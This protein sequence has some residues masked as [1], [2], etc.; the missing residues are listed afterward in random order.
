MRT[1]VCVFGT[2][3]EA[4]KL[5]PLVLQLQAR[6]GFEVLTVST[7]QHREMVEQ[8]TDWFG[9]ELDHD[10]EIMAPRQSLTDIVSRTSERLPPVLGEISPDL[11]VVQGDTSTAFLG[12]L[13]AFYGGIPV[14][15]VEAGLRTGTI[16]N[17]FP[18][19]LNRV[20]ISKIAD[21]HF[22]PSALARSNLIADGIDRKTIWMTG[23]TGVDAFRI[24]AGAI[25]PR[26]P[27]DGHGQ[28]LLVTLH[29]RE[30]WG[31][32]LQEACQ[33]LRML[34]DDLPELEIVFPMHA[35][36]VVRETVEGVL[37]GLRRVKLVEHMSYPEFCA[38]I[39]RSTLVL[40][41]SGGIQEEAPA[42]GVPVLVYRQTT[43]RQ[44]AIDAGTARLVPLDGE[45]VRSVARDLLTDPVRW[46][47][48][49]EA[50]NPYG[51][52]FA[53]GRIVDVLEKWFTA[54]VS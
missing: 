16:R 30:N 28:R 23:N 17:P 34:L 51:D 45:S 53:S 50:V 26:D 25:G 39:A 33:G 12:A 24:T 20:L 7:G 41:D 18:E 40:T 10:L 29:R 22:A 54:R 6:R 43:E 11:V 46:H 3:P 27:S 32:P 21:L 36:P 42:L 52:G 15:H 37:S 1:V 31:R 5:A 4:I 9:L 38:E 13:L 35:N 47:A 48:M 49:A 8:V 14:A 44:E 2:R 19:E